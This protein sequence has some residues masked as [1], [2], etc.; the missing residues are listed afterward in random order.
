M[1]QGKAASLLAAIAIAAVAAGVQAAEQFPQRPVRLIIPYAPGGATDITAR[2]LQPRIAEL[3]GQPVIVDNRPGA[4]G[5]IAL[6]LAARSAPDGYTLFVGNVSTN[7]INETTFRS[8]KVK[9]SRDLTGVTNLI[10]LPHLWVVNPSIPANTLKELVAHV[11]K[12]GARLNYG[13]AGV[14]AYPHL[15]AVKFLRIAGIEMTHVPYKGG[16]GQMIPAIMGNEVQ[17]MFI[18]MAS[19]LPHIRTGRIKPLAITTAQ[20]RPELPSVPTT[21]ESGFPGVG[22]NAWNGL[23]APAAIPKPLLKR[24]HGDVVKVMQGPQM[25]AALEKVFMSVV[26]DPSPEAFQQ[27]VL[28]EIKAWGRIVLDNDIKVE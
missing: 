9:P 8:L 14:G 3:W 12:T 1:R 26:V 20:R 23:F 2:Q 16:A 13:S 7:A 4:S 11:K 25:R 18:N 24:L 5:N 6:E 28:K 21:A 19:S 10:Q 17:F 22:T 15:D 27:F